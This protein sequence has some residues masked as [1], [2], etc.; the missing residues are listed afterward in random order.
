MKVELA[1]SV[2]LVS[3]QT[4]M[5]QMELSLHE[6]SPPSEAST[7]AREKPPDPA[8]ESSSLQLPSSPGKKKKLLQIGRNIYKHT[9]GHKVLQSFVDHHR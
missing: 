8:P 4:E 7:L 6:P 5:H 2:E 1:I 9:H 3:I